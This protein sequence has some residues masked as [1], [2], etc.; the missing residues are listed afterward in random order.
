VWRH[1]YADLQAVA[2]PADEA[3]GGTLGDH[4]VRRPQ[5]T[6][7]DQPSDE[8]V[9]AGVRRVGHDPERVAGP[10]ERCRVQ[11]QHRDLGVGETIS[12]GGGARRV[13]LDRQHPAAGSCER[14]GQGTVAGP[15]VDDDVTGPDG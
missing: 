11:L 10:A 9:D 12:Q 2:V 5:V 13:E 1:P 14:A 4:Q 6:D 15:Q 3:P 8:R 7:G